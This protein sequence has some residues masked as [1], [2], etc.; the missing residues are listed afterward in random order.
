MKRVLVGEGGRKGFQE[1]KERWLGRPG[2]DGRERDRFK[3]TEERHG[4]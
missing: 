1:R 2:R 4:G 3:E